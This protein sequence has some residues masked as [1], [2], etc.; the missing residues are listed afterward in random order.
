MYYI[1]TKISPVPHFDLN[2]TF[3]A[4]TNVF[5]NPLSDGQRLSEAV[6]PPPSLASQFMSSDNDI[7]DTTQIVYLKLPTARDKEGD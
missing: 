2:I 5:D 1:K 4:Q 3:K 6:W 7:F